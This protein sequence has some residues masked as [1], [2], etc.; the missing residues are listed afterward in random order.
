MAYQGAA[1]NHDWDAMFAGLDTPQNNGVTA[2]NPLGE[3][4]ISG[5]NGSTHA[6]EPVSPTSGGGL[7]APSRPDTLQRSLTGEDDPILKDLTNM[8]YPRDEA[9]QALEKYDYNLDVV[10]Q[11]IL[12]FSYIPCVKPKKSLILK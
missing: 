2:T 6:G 4:T 9:L 12:L 3:S 8:G 11:L 7:K 1:Q 10:S 5:P